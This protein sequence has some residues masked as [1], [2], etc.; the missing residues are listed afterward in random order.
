MFAES[1]QAW[2]K[3][4]GKKYWGIDLK[5][6]PTSDY[7]GIRGAFTT[8]NVSGW[9]AI[10][11]GDDT[12]VTRTEITS[13]IPNYFLKD[14]EP[15]ELSGSYYQDLDTDDKEKKWRVD[16]PFPMG[17]T[18][19]YG[20]TLGDWENINE[21]GIN[22]DK[23]G[24][25]GNWDYNLTGNIDQDKDYRLQADIGTDNVGVGGWFDADGNWHAG[26]KASWQWGEPE[27][28]KYKS[29][30][31]NSPKE[32]WTKIQKE[33]LFSNGGIAG[34]RQGYSKGKGVDLARRGFLQ[35]LGGTV[36]GV[37]ALKAGVLKVLGKSGTK[38]VPKIVEIGKGSGVPE[39]FEPMVNKVLAD[40]IDVTKGNAFLDAQ[41]VK[42][43]DT[44]NG[45]VQV[46][47]NERS[48][49]IDVEYLG[50]NTALDEGVHMNY[51]PSRMLADE[52]APNPPDEF[53]ASESIPEG[54]QTGPD[55]YDIEMGENTVGDVKGLY[56][57][58]TELAELGGQKPLIKD[59][60]ETVKKKK[61]LKKMED[62]PVDFVT[63]VQGDYV[64]D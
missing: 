53:M 37:A 51:K 14:Q 12:D 30:T 4:E 6:K 8:E 21:Y 34:L 31:T 44:P 27:E 46:Y 16:V 29:Y 39:W 50:A 64:P 11:K 20:Q 45:E 32:A 3:N 55:D 59:I 58:T 42:K 19:Y 63:D 5:S 25:V 38:A 52:G 40:G 62:N 60:V 57:D 48:G 61:V 22:L 13:T 2:E 33:N 7:K 1:L 41:T 49:E 24:K 26:I 35:L 54:R 18:P 43:L 10:E 9:S 23:S 28:K 47:H 17:I 15:I 36:A 56:S